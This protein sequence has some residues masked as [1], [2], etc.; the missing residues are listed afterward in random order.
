ME[1]QRSAKF[2]QILRAETNVPNNNYKPYRQ[3]DVSHNTPQLKVPVGDAVQ[4]GINPTSY[5][6]IKW[7]GGLSGSHELIAGV[8]MVKKLCTIDLL[9]N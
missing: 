5:G 3:T 1:R 6:T 8:E 9:L 2:H 4:S 7:I